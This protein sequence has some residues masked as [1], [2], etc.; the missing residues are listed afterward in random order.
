ML[1]IKGLSNA[2]FLLNTNIKEVLKSVSQNCHMS[3]Y[4]SRLLSV[5]STSVVAVNHDRLGEK[6]IN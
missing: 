2:S 4:D 6:Y 3:V 5:A 1:V